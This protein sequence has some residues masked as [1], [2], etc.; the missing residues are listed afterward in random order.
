MTWIVEIDI[1]ALVCW[2]LGREC[3]VTGRAIGVSGTMQVVR[4]ELRIGQRPVVFLAPLVQPHDKEFHWLVLFHTVV[5]AFEPVIE[6]AQL[7]SDEVDHIAAGR[8]AIVALRED[9]DHPPVG[10]GTDH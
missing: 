10:P 8:Q 6:P 4:A 5:L 7:H 2:H 3:A 9:A 1:L